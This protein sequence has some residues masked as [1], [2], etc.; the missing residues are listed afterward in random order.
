MSSG[1]LVK[2]PLTLVTLGALFRLSPVLY[3]SMML[4]TYCHTR[5]SARRLTANG[6]NWVKFGSMFVSISEK[7]FRC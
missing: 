2:P 3:M 6:V 7:G 5:L 4:Y 1:P